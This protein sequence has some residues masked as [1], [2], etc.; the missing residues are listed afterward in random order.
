MG[1]INA[2]AQSISDAIKPYT[3]GNPH[4][5]QAEQGLMLVLAVTAALAVLLTLRKTNQ[6]KNG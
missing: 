3:D 5:A 4:V 2:G 6:M 1:Q